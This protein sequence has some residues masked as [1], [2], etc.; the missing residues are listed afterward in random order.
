VSAIAGEMRAAIRPAEIIPRIM[1]REVILI[2]RALNYGGSIKLGVYL[3]S[4]C[5]S[6][7]KKGADGGMARSYRVKS[8]WC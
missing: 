5:R 3:K 7:R 6:R 2:R 8:A 4:W 1:V